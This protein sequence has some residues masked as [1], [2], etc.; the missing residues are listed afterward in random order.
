[1]TLDAAKAL[2]NKITEADLEHAAVFSELQR[3]RD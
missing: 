2:A 1:M 3:I